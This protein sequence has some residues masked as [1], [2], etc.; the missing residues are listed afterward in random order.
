MIR[1]SWTPCESSDLYPS[2]KSLCCFIWSSV[3]EWNHMS[4]NEKNLKL[5]PTKLNKWYISTLLTNN[6]L[7]KTIKP[8]EILPNDT[9]C[10]LSLDTLKARS[11]LSNLVQPGHSP[12]FQQEDGYY[13]EVP[14]SLKCLV[15]PK[16]SS[17]SSKPKVPNICF[18]SM[19]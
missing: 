13:P 6:L 19:V 11:A 1:A 4:S 15:I 2:Q 18:S 12:H 16:A 8:W 10:S 7:T 5:A 9:V 3:S 17:H 14:S